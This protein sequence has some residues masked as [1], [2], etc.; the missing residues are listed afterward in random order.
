MFRIICCWLL[1]VKAAIEAK[2]VNAKEARHGDGQKQADVG[3]SGEEHGVD[4]A[5]CRLPVAGGMDCGS[6]PAMTT[7]VTAPVLRMA[8]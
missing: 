2:P 6:V 1:P 3:D 8:L 5:G 7:W 4:V